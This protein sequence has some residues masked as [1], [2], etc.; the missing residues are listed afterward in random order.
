M[1]GIFE[2]ASKIASPLALAGFFGA[3]L[4][5]TLRRILQAHFI[6]TVRRDD[7]ARILLRI[8]NLLFAISFLATLLG[9]LGY[10]LRMRAEAGN[11][12]NDA[13]TKAAK[14]V[15]TEIV[16]ETESAVS[17]PLSATISEH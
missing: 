14:A 7:S 15:I 8:I 12:E 10:V 11:A 9:F 17:T 1:N 6:S 3:V 5:L 16:D 13:F 2:T 4:F